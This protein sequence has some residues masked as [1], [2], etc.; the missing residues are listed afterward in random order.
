M[1]ALSEVGEP[2]S[3][4]PVR[5]NTEQTTTFKYVF[6]NSDCFLVARGTFGV[7]NLYSDDISSRTSSVCLSLSLS[8]CLCPV[9]TTEFHLAAWALD[10]DE[11]KA[12]YHGNVVPFPFRWS[13]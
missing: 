7:I 8:L 1:S 5:L 2:I 12:C 6:I 13:S 4:C 3:Q 10:S 11:L 9:V